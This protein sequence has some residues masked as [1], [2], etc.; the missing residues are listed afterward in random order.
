LERT[1]WGQVLISVFLAFTIGAILVVNLPDSEL[2][3]D[4]QRVTDPYVQATGLDQNWAIF[5]HPRT[6]SAYVDARVDFADGTTRVVPIPASHGLGTIVRYRW[7]KYEEIIRPDTGRPFW[8]DYARFVAATSRGPGR[9]PVRVTLLRRYAQTR[10]PGPGPER[11]P[12]SE[13]SFFIYDVQG[14]R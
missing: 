8:A 12:W 14:S 6:I 7:Q 5:S 2:R 11:G 10:P 3:A 1:L 13:S 4:L 9:V